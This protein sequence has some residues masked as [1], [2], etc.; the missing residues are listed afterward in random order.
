MQTKRPDKE[1]FLF[2]RLKTFYIILK[3]NLTLTSE[4]FFLG[5]AQPLKE[6]SV[7]GP[8][9]EELVAWVGQLL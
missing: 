2:A 3:S 5:C 1:M 4:E 7:V 9:L 8:K 6:I